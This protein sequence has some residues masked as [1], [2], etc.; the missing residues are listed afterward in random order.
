MK[1][2]KDAIIAAETGNVSEFQSIVSDILKDKLQDSVGIKK[3]EIASKFFD[4][5][6]E[7]DSGDEDVA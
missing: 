5:Y 6:A 1:T 2:T 3:F 4:K 7:E